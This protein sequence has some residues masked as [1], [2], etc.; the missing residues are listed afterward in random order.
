MSTVRYWSLVWG[1]LVTWEHGKAR[2]ATC[3]H[4]LKQD[5]IWPDWNQPTTYMGQIQFGKPDSFDDRAGFWFM[6]YAL[7][8]WVTIMLSFSE[9]LLL[10]FWNSLGSTLCLSPWA[11]LSHSIFLL[12]SLRRRNER[13]PLVE[14]ICLFFS[15]FPFCLPSS[16]FSV[17]LLL[18]L[19][20]DL[21]CFL[22][23][24]FSILILV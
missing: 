23:G 6:F 1:N 19:S 24:L 13:K 5:K 2:K 20:F 12:W 7:T 16:H 9:L 15:L 18:W 8:C 14:F 21:G 4:T 3:C 22:S 10:P 11:P 17:C